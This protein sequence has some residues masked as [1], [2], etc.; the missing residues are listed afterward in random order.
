M[1]PSSLSYAADNTY[2]TKTHNL[3]YSLFST[4]QDLTSNHQYSPRPTVDTGRGLLSGSGT[5]SNHRL[6]N[7]PDHSEYLESDA[8]TSTSSTEDIPGYNLNTHVPEK[9]AQDTPP[10]PPKPV[11]LSIPHSRDPEKLA[12]D[13]YTSP[14]FVPDTT[15][16]P[17]SRQRSTVNYS[18]EDVPDD[19]NEGSEH[20]LKT[21]VCI[22]STGKQISCD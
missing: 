19:I 11:H 2:P 6:P 20:H 5:R 14:S 10:Y 18:W 7:S 3:R 15:S 9:S 4:P 8:I 22:S 21:L 16:P 13:V 17:S 1:D 12:S